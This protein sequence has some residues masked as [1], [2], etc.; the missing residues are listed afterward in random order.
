MSDRP[1]PAA[2]ACANRSWLRLPGACPRPRRSGPLFLVLLSAAC[3]SGGIPVN[4]THDPLA[5]FPAQATF[6]WDVAANKL[7]EASLLGGLEP[8][9]LIE[10]IAE[11][12]FTARGYRRAVSAAPDYRLSYELA[13]HR[14]I[15][16]EESHATA[17]L[18]F[19]L[20]EASTG[21]RVWLGWGRAEFFVDAALEQRRERMRDA[22]QRMLA[23]F[24]PIQTPPE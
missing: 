11:E 4:S 8:G 9:P 24:P 6:S 1:I 17:S 12:A 22:M 7:P 3:A 2:L 13:V 23:D 21:R 14:F 19:L 15:G 16:V 10:Q 5:R 20:S 18:S